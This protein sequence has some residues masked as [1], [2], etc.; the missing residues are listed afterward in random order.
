MRSNKS[1]IHKAHFSRASDV[2]TLTTIAFAAKSQEQANIVD[3]CDV[4]VPCLQ[5]ASSRPLQPSLLYR[6]YFLGIDLDGR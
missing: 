2:I 1:R 6:L 4:I 3:G 5:Q